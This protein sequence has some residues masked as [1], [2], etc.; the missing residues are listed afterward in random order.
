MVLRPV[1]EHARL[2]VH[3]AWLADA[4]NSSTTPASSLP[5]V[6]VAAGLATMAIGIAARPRRVGAVDPAAGRGR[7]DQRARRLS[8]P[9]GARHTAV[10]AV[11]LLYYWR[12]FDRA[13]VA[14]S[15]LFALLSIVSLLI[16]ATFG[17][18]YLGDE[19]TPPVHD[20]ATAVSIVSMSTVGYGDIVPH[21][22]T[23]RL[24]TASVI[25]LGITVFATSISA[26]VGPVIGGNLKRIVK[27]GISNVI[28]KHH[29]LIVGAT[30]VAHAVHDGCASAATR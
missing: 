17:V 21:A 13:S 1:V 23:A 20:L 2:G 30:P 11:A 12:H 15:S 27:G 16:Y 6:V 8:Q 25:V 5:Q 28:R 22:P 3:H 14:A 4:L 9:R 24:F 26:V 10:L 29:Y 19:F 7:R 18:L